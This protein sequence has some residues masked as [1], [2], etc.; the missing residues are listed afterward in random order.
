M[1]CRVHIL[2]QGLSAVKHI[3]MEIHRNAFSLLLK[4]LLFCLQSYW[5]SIIVVMGGAGCVSL[6]RSG[7]N[8]LQVFDS[9]LEKARMTDSEYANLFFIFL[10]TIK[11][12]RSILSTLDRSKKKNM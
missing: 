1:V 8:S 6:R 4:L 12:C 11:V 9:A 10:F 7:R 2:S 3:H 5:T